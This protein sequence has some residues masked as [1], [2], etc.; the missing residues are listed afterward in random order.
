MLRSN[1]WGQY[2]LIEGNLNHVLTGA[3]KVEKHAFAV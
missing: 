3:A 1:F 2:H